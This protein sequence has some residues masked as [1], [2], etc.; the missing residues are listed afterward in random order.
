MVSC[1]TSPA[2]IPTGIGFWGTLSL[3]SHPHHDAQCL[4][5]HIQGWG[6]TLRG[7]LYRRQKSLWPPNIQH[8]PGCVAA[9]SENHD[10]Q[11]PREPSFMISALETTSIFYRWRVWMGKWEFTSPLVLPASD[12]PQAIA[13]LPKRSGDLGSL[14][15]C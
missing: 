15:T 1:K 11:L 2:S 5:A 6:T 3:C 13:N 9:A 10:P 7:P 12:Y 14:S 8:L 4:C